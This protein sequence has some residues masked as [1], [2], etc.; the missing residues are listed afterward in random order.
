MSLSAQQ[1]YDG[2]LAAARQKLQAGDN[3]AAAA[4][5]KQAE[6]LN[7]SRWEAHAVAG[8][9]LM[10]LKLWD[11]AAD[12]LSLAI[13]AA[14]ESKKATLRDLRKQCVLADSGTVPTSRSV[15]SSPKSG[16]T[17][18]EV[19]LWKS[20]EHSTNADDF[21]GYIQGYPQ[22]AFVPLAKQ[23][24]TE[25][26][27]AADAVQESVAKDA[28]RS[29]L[30]DL[31]R[32]D[33]YLKRYP[34]G[35]HAALFTAQLPQ[36]RRRVDVG[37]IAMMLENSPVF[38]AAIDSQDSCAV[39]VKQAQYDNTDTSFAHSLKNPMMWVPGANLTMLAVKEGH[40]VKFDTYALD[41]AALKPTDIE[42]T[43]TAVNINLPKAHQVDIQLS[44]G[45]AHAKDPAKKIMTITPNSCQLPGDKADRCEVA[46]AQPYRAV[47]PIAKD[48]DRSVYW[49]LYALMTSAAADCSG[50][51][52][53][54]GT[55]STPIVESKPAMEP[56]T[57]VLSAT[58]AAV[59]ALILPVPKPV[60]AARGSNSILHIYRMP[61]FT[62]GGVAVMLRLDG[63]NSTQLQ[64][65][66]FALAYVQPG[67]HTITVGKTNLNLPN[68]EADKDY[69]IR[70]DVNGGPVRIQ[71]V[72]ADKGS[73][74]AKSLPLAGVV[75]Q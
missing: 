28:V 49:Q 73:S 26:D 7:A 15:A 53:A 44:G 61:H 43:D 24:L 18:A 54:A 36:I 45:S 14:P 47:V 13:T 57:P 35:A 3:E 64:S 41:F 68:T 50:M 23:H 33:A 72:D 10:N 4:A 67:E 29:D 30:G 12:E 62:G 56:P 70:V 11:A 48:A 63:S 20:I 2:Q 51:P 8:G 5:A 42:M 59:A 32:V 46:V 58:S 34:S 6:H 55:T 31:D 52:I 65:G 21:R 16:I 60:S 66:S 40:E 17:Q 22:G 74:E 71:V 1:T 9:A 19:V 69:W 38:N 39:M 37:K 75:T 25:L 27:N